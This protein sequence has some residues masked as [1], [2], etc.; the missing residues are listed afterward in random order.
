MSDDLAI[1]NPEQKTVDFNGEQIT[2]TPV[3]MGNLQAFTAVM[4]P[5][6]KDVIMA[7]E[8]DGD[9]L[10]TIELH[11]NRMIE[12]VSIGTGISKERLDQCLPDEFL[13]LAVAV[14]EINADFFVRRLLP[15]VVASVQAMRE[16]VQ[17]LG[18]TRFSA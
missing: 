9:L 7:L 5:I 3:R 2:I 18:T 15:S 8:G 12:A 1:L 16:K 10:M 4:R 13:K 11:G 14:I 6:T 17:E